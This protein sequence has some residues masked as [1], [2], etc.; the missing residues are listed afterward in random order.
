MHPSTNETQSPENMAITGGAITAAPNDTNTTSSSTPNDT[1]TSMHNTV[2]S[3][4]TVS[5]SISTVSSIS[6]DSPTKAPAVVPDWGI[7]LLVLAA[8][9]LLLLIILLI[10][11]LVM[12]CCKKNRRTF[13]KESE[14]ITPTMYFNPDIPMYSTH[15]IIESANGKQVDVREKPP[16][17]RTGMY[18]VNK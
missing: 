13:V 2:N 12:C 6:T 9:S 1:S 4:S 16:A 5:S 7:A 10:I 17:N 3:I 15:S 11:L 18:V 14:A 8:I